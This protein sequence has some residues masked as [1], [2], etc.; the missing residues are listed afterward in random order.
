MSDAA[1]A[2]N[3]QNRL[4]LFIDNVDETTFHWRCYDAGN[5]VSETG[6]T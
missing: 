1:R 6:G 3:L 4:V 2:A 5:V